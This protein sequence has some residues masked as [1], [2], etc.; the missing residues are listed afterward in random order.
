MKEKKNHLAL[1]HNIDLHKGS[2][3]LQCISLNMVSKGFLMNKWMPVLQK[4][5]GHLTRNKPDMK[6]ALLLKHQHQQWNGH[7]LN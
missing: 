3:S 7:S 6:K 2:N 1:I 4:K 5:S